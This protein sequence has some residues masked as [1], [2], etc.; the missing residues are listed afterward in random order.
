ME[1]H[2]LND[3]LD[4]LISF[5]ADKEEMEFWRA[6]YPTWPEEKKPTLDRNFLRNW[7][8]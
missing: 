1:I 5:G 3:I 7:L 8:Y 6:V 4:E 2:Q